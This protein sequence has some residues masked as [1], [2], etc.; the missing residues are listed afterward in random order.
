MK[1]LLAI[2]EKFTKEPIA[3]T[4]FFTI[5]CIGYLYLDNKTNYQHQIE[6]CGTKVDMLERKVSLLEDKLKVSDSLLVRAL[7][8]LESINAQQ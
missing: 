1:E 6:A 2:L 4:L 8:K 7:V 3:G 5:I